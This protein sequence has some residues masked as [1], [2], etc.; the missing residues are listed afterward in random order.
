MPRLSR[1][2]QRAQRAATIAAFAAASFGED[3]DEDREQKAEKA[4][5]LTKQPKFPF[6]P[7]DAKD[8]LRYNGKEKLAWWRKKVSEHWHS[9][10]PDMN[11]LR[12]WAEKQTEHVT[13]ATIKPLRKM[14]KEPVNDPSSCPIICGAG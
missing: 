1:T 3:E 14:M 12:M 8:L 5:P 6:D 9:K 7:K 2:P 13:N 11:G 10:Y 4:H